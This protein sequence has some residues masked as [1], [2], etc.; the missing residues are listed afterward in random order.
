MLRNYELVWI[1]GSDA[2][3]ADGDAAVEKVRAVVAERGGEVRD[4]APWGRRT[5]AYPIHRNT[6][7]LYLVAHFAADS[8]AAQDIER[9]V[10]ADQSVIRHL[11]VRDEPSKEDEGSADDGNSE[12]SSDD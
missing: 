4:A 5:L 1:L 6:E 11:M 9:S 7:G 3:D 2:T 8:R 10:Q 12:D